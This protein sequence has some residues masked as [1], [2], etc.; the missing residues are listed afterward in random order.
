[1]RHAEEVESRV[2]ID[3]RAAESY[4]SE[5]RSEANQVGESALFELFRWYNSVE[6]E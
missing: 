2:M 6:N 5:V 4:F 1:M 3:S